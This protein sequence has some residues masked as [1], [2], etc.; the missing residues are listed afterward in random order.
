MA[1]DIKCD[2]DPFNHVICSY[3]LQKRWSKQEPK[4]A[5]FKLI[6]KI[7]GLIGIVLGYGYFTMLCYE[8][9]GLFNTSGWIRL[10]LAVLVVSGWINIIKSSFKLLSEKS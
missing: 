10:L 7:F 2:C 1:D 8:A 9:G 5:I 6:K 4:R 3:H